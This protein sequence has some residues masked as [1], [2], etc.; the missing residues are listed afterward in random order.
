MKYLIGFPPLYIFNLLIV[1]LSLLLDPIA[2]FSRSKK[3]DLNFEFA[4]FKT[5]VQ[6]NAEDI[7]RYKN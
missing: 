5:I 4:A 1:A 7:L 2:G 3:Q 6:S